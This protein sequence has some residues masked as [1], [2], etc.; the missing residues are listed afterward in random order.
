MTDTNTDTRTDVTFATA[1]GTTLAGWFYRPEAAPVVAGN[2]CI[3]MSPGLGAVRRMQ[4]ESYARTFSDAGFAC[5]LY[6][7]RNFADSDGAPR[8]EADPWRQLSDMR[9]AVTFA[10]TRPGVDPSRIGVWGASYSGGHALVIGALDRRVRAVVA[11]VPFID[12]SQF[13]WADDDF[14]ASLD[15]DRDARARGEAPAVMHPAYDGSDNKAWVDAVDGWDHYPNELTLRSMDL[16]R[17]YMPK[18]FVPLIAPTPMLMVIA[19]ND[20]YPPCSPAISVDAWE[21]GGEP[22]AIVK[23]PC[24]HYDMY[25]TYLTEA[26]TASRDFFL[27]HL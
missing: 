18:T 5:L 19:E 23:L 20:A 7:H 14:W 4:F 8:H 11:Q 12:G 26:A 21:A 3:V 25:S 2:P 1:D 24:G 13:G 10:R 16:M 15:A 6:D 17:T 9:D 27:E 22:K